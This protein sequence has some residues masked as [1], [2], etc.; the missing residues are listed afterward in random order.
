VVIGVGAL[1]VTI[2]AVAAGTPTFTAASGESIV[3]AASRSLPLLPASIRIENVRPPIADSLLLES[4]AASYFAIGQLTVEPVE[5]MGATPDPAIPPAGSG[6]S[7]AAQTPTPVALPPGLRVGLQAG[8]WNSAALPAE[9][10]SLRTATGTSGGG[11]RE[12]ELNLDIARRVAR[13]L[14]AQGIQ[15]D[16]LPA[17]VPPGYR[18]DA[19]V[20]LHA[21]GSG[22][23]A[24]SGFKLARSSQSAI[25]R[26]DDALLA[27]ITQTYGA[28]TG[29]REDHNI[30]RNMTGYY[31]FSS[32]R[33][34]HAIAPT[35]PSVIVEMG[36]LTNASDREVLSQRDT[37][38]KGIADGIL[39][40]L[41]SR[42]ASG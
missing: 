38:A 8:H 29:L 14:E 40:F 30:T 12:W 6:E 25:P 17:T 15:A 1:S 36:F 9:L 34:Q 20:A 28:A 7:L 2:G 4:V 24:P 33:Y 10:A 41:S 26:V 37:V 13:L 32:R 23:S 35:T 5:A 11:V 22:S 31:A 42:Q 21:D 19:F 27:A 18:A 39:R 16:V 3:T